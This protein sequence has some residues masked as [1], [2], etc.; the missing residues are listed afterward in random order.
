VVCVGSGDATAPRPG[1]AAVAAR[2]LAERLAARG[3]SA[4]AR[5]R[6]VT[7]ALPA[8]DVEARAAADRAMA[9]AGDAPVVLVLAGARPPALD[10]LLAAVDRVVLVPPAEA[11]SGLEALA[12]T[13]AAH[14]GRSTAILRLPRTG[15]ATNHLLSA[16]GL[17]LS[18]S[19]RGAA[20]RALEG[21]PE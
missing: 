4:A 5:G 16:T 11:P 8:S 15:S 12:L 10:P 7:V 9:A 20:T 2:R 17:S 13:A 1:L 18:P 6:L 14:L 19:L 3:L 21:G